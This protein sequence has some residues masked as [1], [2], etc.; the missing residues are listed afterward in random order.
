VTYSSVRKSLAVLICLGLVAVVVAGCSSPGGTSAGK[1]V[2]VGET[3][4][5]D[6]LK[7]TVTAVNKAKEVG[8]AGNTFTMKDGDFVVLDMEVQNSGD[9]ATAF[10][11][12]MAKMYDAD[13]NLYELNLEASAAACTASEANGFNN[14]WFGTLQP[15]EKAKTKAV[16]DI[17]AG[18]KGL[19]VEL[20]SAEIG[21]TNTA[22]VSLG[23]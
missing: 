20:R 2:N 7:Y 11:G 17:P 6:N 22:V 4:K 3:V 9:K 12:E 18:I 5:L 1:T 16:F 23:I 14:V 8:K 19:K 13:N 10:D 21:S 15:G